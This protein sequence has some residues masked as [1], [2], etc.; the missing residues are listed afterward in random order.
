[1][2][3]NSSEHIEVLIIDDSAFSRHTIKNILEKVP[4]I[5]VIGIAIDGYD[6]MT[7]IMNLNP[8]VV[9]LDLE[10]PK[11]DG[12]SLLRWIMKE[13]PLPVIIVSA[14]GDNPTVFKA[15]ELGA[16]D[17]VEKPARRASKDL[18]NIENDLLNKII[19]IK[20]LSIEKHQKTISR[21][22]YPD[23]GDYLGSDVSKIKKAFDMVAVGASTG[24]PAA[25]QTILGNLPKDFPSGV[26]ISQHMPRGFT[27]QFA[28]RMNRMSPVEV[29]EA[30]QGEPVKDGKALICPGGFHMTLQR[31]RKEVIVKIQEP[32]QKDRYIPSIDIMMKSAAEIYR[33]RILGVVLTGMGYDGKE[34]MLEITENG[35]YTIAESE[36]SS[37]V[38]GM[39]QAVISS[40]AAKKI[41]SLERISGEILRKM[42]SSK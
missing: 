10:M 17:F 39:P 21:L 35:G 3:Q 30:E 29:K 6:G 28:E 13:R 42:K 25:L 1:M 38:F 9:T 23:V 7:K 4:G 19:G 24:G 16:V 14:Y 32:S 27:R 31:S 26:I 22:S 18:K 33:E 15:L 34:G 36:E 11:M 8:D 20:S 40:G 12:F 5:K 2:K 41:L 37:V